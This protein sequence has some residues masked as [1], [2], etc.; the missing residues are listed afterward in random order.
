MGMTMIT[1]HLLLGLSKL[2]HEEHLELGVWE[3]LNQSLFQLVLLCVATGLLSNVP[4]K[5]EVTKP[6]PE[7]SFPEAMDSGVPD[8]PTKAPEAS[9][10]TQGCSSWLPLHL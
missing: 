5:W 2:T 4:K 10:C 9:P 7:P 6:Q 1:P 3:L 8:L